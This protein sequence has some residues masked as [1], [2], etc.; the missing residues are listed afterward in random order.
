MDFSNS[1]KRIQND[2]G[3][4]FMVVSQL[5]GGYLVRDDTTSD[6]VYFKHGDVASEEDRES[7]L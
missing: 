6:L 4:W 2:A 5:E 7:R 1:P 3:R